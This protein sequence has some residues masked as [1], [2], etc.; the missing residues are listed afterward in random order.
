[1]D[2]KAFQAMKVGREARQ[3]PKTGIRSI[4]KAD[5]L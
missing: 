2:G 4:G 1:M 5:A 3:S